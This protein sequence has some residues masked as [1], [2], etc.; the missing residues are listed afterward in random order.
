MEE[1]KVYHQTI[2]SKYKVQFERSATAK[3]VIGFKVE[4]NGDIAFD[5]FE[6]AKMLKD[7]AELYAPVL[8][9][10]EAKP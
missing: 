4:A 5:T 2:G 7:R 9:E 6:D 3:G 1:S 10:Q 8:K